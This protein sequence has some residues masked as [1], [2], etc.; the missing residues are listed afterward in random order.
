MAQKNLPKSLVIKIFSQKLSPLSQV[1]DK[2]CLFSNKLNAKSAFINFATFRQDFYEKFA[3][4][5]VS[6]VISLSQK[7]K[8]FVSSLEPS[9]PIFVAER[10]YQAFFYFR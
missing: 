4:I 7:L 8:F 5:S 9:K 6:L 3:K 10:R 1:A 2:V